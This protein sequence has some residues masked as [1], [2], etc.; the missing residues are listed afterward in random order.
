MQTGQ[1]EVIQKFF[2]KPDMNTE[3]SSLDAMLN[4][5]IILLQPVRSLRRQGE[6]E[7][8]HGSTV[9]VF[10]SEDRGS[11]LSGGL[12]SGPIKNIFQV[13]AFSETKT[14]KQKRKS[15]GRNLL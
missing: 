2:F 6:N 1:T 8:P 5:V 4:P 7:E 11:S 14:N 12:L 15:D 10:P 9:T 3:L 13:N